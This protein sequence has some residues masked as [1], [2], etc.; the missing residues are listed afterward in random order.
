MLLNNFVASVSL[1]R[2]SISF[3]DKF[4]FAKAQTFTIS[5]K[6]PDFFRSFQED[7][8]SGGYSQ[9]LDPS[10]FLYVILEKS[11]PEGN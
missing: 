10:Q 11:L 4:S 9:P 6:S 2:K 7:V 8:Q 1:M 5:M 3:L